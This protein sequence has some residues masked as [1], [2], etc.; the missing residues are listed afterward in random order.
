[1]EG[2]PK[3]YQVAST[4]SQIAQPAEEEGANGTIGLP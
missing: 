3:K 1:M 4:R 2:A